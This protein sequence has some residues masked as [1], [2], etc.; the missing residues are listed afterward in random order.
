MANSQATTMATN[1]SAAPLNLP[2]TSFALCLA[3]FMQVLDGTIANVALPTI[4][5]ELGASA[6]Q[7]TWII[8]AFVVCN[9]ITL[10][11]TG[12]L[13][14]TFGEV[15]LFVACTF[16]FV[17][18]SFLCG[19][20][21]GL[22]ELVLFRALQGAVAGPMYP[23]TQSLMI[24][25]YPSNK[26][27][28]ALATLAM[29]TTVAPVAGPILGGWI[30]SNYAWGWIFF[31]NVPLGLLA[32]A[33][34][35]LQMRHRPQSKVLQKVDYIGLITLIVGIGALQIML[36]LGNERDWFADDLIITLSIIAAIG[37]SLFVYWELTTQNPIVDLGL[38]FK[39]RNFGLGTLCLMLGFAAFF[40]INLLIPLWAQQVLRYDQLWT[41]WVA[42]P[43]GILPIIFAP[44][45]GRYA[46][47]LDMR[48]LATFAYLVFAATSFWRA[49][50]N[51]E[52]SASYIAF[53]QFILGL[54]V[55]CFFM[56]LLTILMSDLSG[57]EIA[58]GSGVQAFLRQVGSSF[59]TSLTIY[60]WQ[61]RSIIHHADLAVH[62]NPQNHAAMQTIA[63]FDDPQRGLASINQL[64][65]QQAAQM[66]FNDY[67]YMLGWI[68][69]SLVVLVWL[70]KRVDPN[71]HH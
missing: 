1:S 57:S 35:Y 60:F 39:H 37:L 16:L 53:T 22:H 30:T 10:P 19:I 43:M 26:R 36:D 54:G 41:G 17:V 33:V 67:L 32:S 27:G 48:W 9:A 5:G 6:S 14:K 40:G 71:K 46:N 29:V 4:A 45:L 7:S 70:T 68:F 23:L 63:L 66:A 62:I 2:V 3:V 20:A 65:D 52:I 69:L 21:T 56:P 28:S 25:I 59:A 42:A 13:A 24:S 34:V 8:T 44:I 58:S 51:T 11:L 50:F 12:F 47:R 15:K 18:T 64:I 31:I 61:H 55:A 49:H 38:L